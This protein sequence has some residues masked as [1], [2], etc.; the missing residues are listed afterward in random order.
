[1]VSGSK[2]QSS[3]AAFKPDSSMELLA[4]GLSSFKEPA[5]FLERA[6][7]FTLPLD[8]VYLKGLKTEEVFNTVLLN[9]YQVKWIYIF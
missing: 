5:A 8:N 9:N 1:M 6:D 2:Q 4:A 3:E 7:D